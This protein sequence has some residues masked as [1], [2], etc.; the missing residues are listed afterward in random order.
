[1]K[2]NLRYLP[3][4][5]T[6]KDRKNQGKEL[7]KSRRLYKKGIYHSRPKLTSFKSK[8]SSHIIKAE[9]MYNVDKIGPT[10]ELSKA[11][12]C[13]K[14]SLAKIINKGAGA[15]F[16]S[17]SRPNQTA[18]SWGIARL[19]SAITSGKASAVDYNILEE[20]CKA[21]SKALTLAKRAKAKYGNGTRRVPKV[22][23]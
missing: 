22:K 17:G 18:Q 16:S 21:K 5:L 23:L 7:M 2:I 8:K 4:R 12:G 3:K 14:S 20:G 10:D 6:R 15:Y 9:K 13:S 1:M 19:A 11:T